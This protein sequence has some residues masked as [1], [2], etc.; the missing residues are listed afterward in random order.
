MAA[1][2]PTR[3]V[4][5]TSA[6][7]NDGAPKSLTAEERKEIYAARRFIG[8]GVEKK[9][10]LR[11]PF[12]VYFQDPLVA[13]DNPKL[14]FDEDCFVPWEPGLAD[15]PTSARFA[16]V[17]YDAHT[18]TLAPPARWD[19]K[20]DGFVAPERQAARSPQHR[21]VPQFHQ[22]NAW[23][24]LQRA[25]E[26]FEDGFGLGPPHSLGIRGQPADRRPARRA[27]R[28]RLLRSR[29]QVAAVLLLRSRRRAHLHLP[30]DG[31]RPSRVRPRGAR[32]HPAAVH[33][34]GARRKRRRSTNSSAT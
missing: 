31:H 10:K 26:F 11:I 5:P 23:A 30:V 4:P 28:E 3:S 21:A 8:T 34:G 7:R 27:R 22:V 9:L 25:L 12:D 24:I 6:S 15:G 14:A 29:E 17:D 19:E 33:R 32:R 20:R 2:R 1:K 18:D 13:A 16:V